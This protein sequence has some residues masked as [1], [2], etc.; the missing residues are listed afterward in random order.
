MRN[1]LKDTL[2][3]EKF[4][5]EITAPAVEE[6]SLIASSEKEEE[7]V[8]H[9][10][11]Y[12]MLGW[13]WEEISAA[14]EDMG[15]SESMI[16]RA[17]KETQ[18]YAIQVINDGPFRGLKAG[19]LVKMNNGEVVQVVSI[20]K[21]FIYGVDTKAASKIQILPEQIDVS[22]SSVLKE[23]H[24]LRCSAYRMITAAPE[25]NVNPL[26]FWKD[27][28][29]QMVQPPSPKMTVIP[30]ETEK[31]DVKVQERAP[32][33]WGELTPEMGVVDE[34]NEVTSQAL[35][36]LSA[37]HSEMQ[38]VEE[39]LRVLNVMAKELR[40]KQKE[41]SQKKAALAK[42]VF[43]LVGQ[44]NAALNDLN[45][46][47]FQK[48]QGKIVGLQRAI[49]EIP[50]EPGVLDELN[51]LKDILATNVPEISASV[52]NTLEEWKKANT[53][54]LE[55]IHETFAMYTPPKSK[56]GNVDEG[57]RVIWAS[58][59]LEVVQESVNDLYSSI[60]PAAEYTSDAIDQFMGLL[61]PAAVSAKIKQA[62]RGR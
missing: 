4:I 17:I 42:E 40:G 8:G 24:D 50:Q 29:D 14:L 10:Q 12:W 52:L 59:S 13:T 22:A 48:W 3:F 23:A 56:A 27:V 53:T 18:V 21:D 37:A 1:N 26:D 16:D 38:S 20:H 43:A 47:V 25:E 19:Q 46:T 41:L 31:L 6:I 5:S 28:P 33:G 15:F 32:S 61:A 62:F 39:D 30:E 35:A 34:V 54:I 44:E 60:F 36:T 45:V 2:Q 9:A 57:M 55:Q 11:S 51:A 49:Q 7:A 58:D